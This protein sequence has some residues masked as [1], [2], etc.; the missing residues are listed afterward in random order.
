MPTYSDPA[1]ILTGVVGQ[2]ELDS[3][4]KKNIANGVAPLDGGSKVPAVNIPINYKYTKNNTDVYHSH[5]AE[6]STS[7]D[8]YVKIKTIDVTGLSSSPLTVDVYFEIASTTAVTTVYAKIYVNG[9]AVGTQRTDASGTSYVGFH[10]D[11]VISNGDTLELWAHDTPGNAC[12]PL[13]RNFRIY[14][15]DDFDNVIGIN[16]TP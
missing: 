11:I 3:T 13:C 2:N 4:A 7:S 16:S 5:D 10:E 6:A 1:L 9:V 15:R 12:A 8:T 14:G